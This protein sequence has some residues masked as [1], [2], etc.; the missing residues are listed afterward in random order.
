M[1][2]EWEKF[3]NYGKK[4]DLMFGLWSELGCLKSSEDLKM[5]M[6]VS[7]LTR[8]HKKYKWDILLTS[9]LLDMSRPKYVRNFALFSNSFPCMRIVILVE[10]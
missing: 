9:R 5:F 8:F 3:N 10:A 1:A 4:I 2:C 6:P 7:Q